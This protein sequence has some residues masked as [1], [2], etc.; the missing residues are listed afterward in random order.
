MRAPVQAPGGSVADFREAAAR[1]RPEPPVD[2]F[3]D[4]FLAVHGDHELNPDDTNPFGIDRPIRSAAVLIPV[5][6][7]DSGPTVLLTRRSDHLPFH[8]GQVSFPGGKVEEADG[9]VLEAALRES[10]E[11]IGLPRDHVTPMGY[12][13]IYQTVTG[14]QVVPVVAS[15]KPG[16]RMTL[17]ENEVAEAF[18]VPLAF[19]MEQANHQRHSRVWNGIRRHYCAMPYGRHYIWGATAGMIRNLRDRLYGG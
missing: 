3:N 2:E 7:H 16:F 12:L 17:D 9:S 15:V 4:D 11:E 10:E 5:I 1:L 13:D 6:E 8:G 18:E 19:L 14:F